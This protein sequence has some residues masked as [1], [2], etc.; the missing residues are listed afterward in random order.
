VLRARLAFFNEQAAE[1]YLISSQAF[2]NYDDSA[3]LNSATNQHLIDP[4]LEFGCDAAK[5]PILA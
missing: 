4:I 1:R 5:Q 3:S 2:N